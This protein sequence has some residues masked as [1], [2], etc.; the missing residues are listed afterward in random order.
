ML[1][2]RNIIKHFPVLKIGFKFKA[3]V[4]LLDGKRK[5]KLNWPFCYKRWK[6]KIN[7]NDSKNV[8]E[9]G[10]EGHV[11]MIETFWCWACMMIKLRNK[12][13]ATWGY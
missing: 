6:V 3:V 13:S 7:H 11:G 9:N 10:D 8:K 2:E 1:L 4:V 5:R 12:A